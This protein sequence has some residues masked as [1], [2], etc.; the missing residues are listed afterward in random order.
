MDKYNVKKVYQVICDGKGGKWR[1][2]T[3]KFNPDFN[4]AEI[5]VIFLNI[6]ESCHSLFQQCMK[7]ALFATLR[8]CLLC[9]LYIPEKKEDIID[10]RLVLCNTVFFAYFPYRSQTSSGSSPSYIR[11]SVSKALKKNE[12]IN[13]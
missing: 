11:T 2:H 7:V 10:I 5:V 13:H 3:Y 4:I 8:K 9:P 1:Y 12:A 6:S